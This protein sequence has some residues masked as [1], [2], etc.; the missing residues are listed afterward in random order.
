MNNV[1]EFLLTIIKV[2]INELKMFYKQNIFLV[3]TKI[4]FKLFKEI[5]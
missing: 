1:F 3:S 4:F 2:P 5:C